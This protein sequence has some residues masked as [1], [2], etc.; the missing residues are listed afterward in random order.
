MRRLLSIA[1]VGIAC[2][3]A[4]VA[5]GAGGGNDALKTFERSAA[6]SSEAP[7]Q[8]LTCLSL[9]IDLNSGARSGSG[10]R[11]PTGVPFETVKAFR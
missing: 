1:V 11:S 8:R 7:G 5:T 6:A 10:T 4:V 2:F 9:A 3:A